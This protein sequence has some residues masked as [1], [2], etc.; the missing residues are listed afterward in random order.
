MINI[1]FFD[2]ETTGLPRDWK[3]PMADVD[4]WPRVIEIAW[5]LV[6]EDGEVLASSDHLIEP[7][8]WTVPE[9]E[10]WITRHMTTERCQLDGIP[11]RSAI[12]LLLEAMARAHVMVAHNMDFDA[13]V[14][15]A[16]MI[17]LGVKSQHK[18]VKICTKLATTQYC[19]IP[20]NPK[21]KVYPG[22]KP[23][24]YKWPNL[25]ELWGALFGK[26]TLTQD[27]R[28]K[29]DVQVLKTCF[30][31]CVRRHIIKLPKEEEATT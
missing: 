11:I 10:F 8:G 3:A 12:E 21:Q 9:E 7:D 27:H 31:E 25:V 24:S 16:E 26:G 13:S 2:V 30:F 6:T 1:L 4:N 19:K 15:G 17:R 29:G 22:S 18:P 28:A 20:Y 5:E 14:I 23:M